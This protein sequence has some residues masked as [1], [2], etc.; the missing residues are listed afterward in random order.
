MTNPV[1]KAAGLGSDNPSAISSTAGVGTHNDVSE[2]M[3]SALT[4]HDL[5]NYRTRNLYTMLRSSSLLTHQ[6]L[7][8]LLN[9]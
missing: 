8:Y 1:N 9:Q 4:E 5:I 3:I 2:I 6:L 7:L